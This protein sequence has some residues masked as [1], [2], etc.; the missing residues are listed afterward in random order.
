M[1]ESIKEQTAGIEQINEAVGQLEKIT[2][3]NLSIA[4]NTSGISKD[5]GQIAQDITN[6]TNKKR[7]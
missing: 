4:D 1:G 3:N 6:D 2:Q 5:V 7:F